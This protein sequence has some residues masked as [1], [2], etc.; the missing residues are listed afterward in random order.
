MNTTNSIAPPPTSARAD[1][2]ALLEEVSRGEESLTAY[3]P[4]GITP[5]RFMALARRA[6]QEQ[7]GLA[8]CSAT[9]VL[10]ALRECALSGLELD[11]K[12]ST[13]IVRK[14]KQG[15]PMATWD[16]TYRGMI[17]LALASGQVRSVEA[18]AVRAADVFTVELGSEPKLIHR[19]LV[20]GARGDVVAVYA[21]ADLAA[22][23]R[24][25]ELLT[26]E[27]IARI[28]AVSPAGDK[29]PWGPWDDEM[30]RKAALRRLLKKLPASNIRRA[31]PGPRIPSPGGQ[32]LTARPLRVYAAL[33]PEDEHAMECRALDQ[34]SS[35]D[36][37]SELDAA[38]TQAQVEYQQRGAAVPL[39]VE[40]R[41][42]ELRESWS[43]HAQ[44]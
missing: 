28:R 31:S 40:A 10:R 17:S 2:N 5:Q 7:P 16:A 6:V 3:L 21:I 35:A 26:A 13:L 38:W 32:R 29:G 27:D 44:P 36:T 8:E 4:E 9:S 12:N 42:R 18:Q 1:V 24:M 30:A 14:S 23:G 43:E 41:W 22:G 20:T 11:G 25:I 15:R 37:V 39:A 19:P 34:L 33:L